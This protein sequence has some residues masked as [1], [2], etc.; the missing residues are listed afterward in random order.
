MGQWWRGG[1][2]INLTDRIQVYFVDFSSHTYFLLLTAV[3]IPVLSAAG[4][5]NDRERQLRWL[6]KPFPGQKRT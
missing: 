5:V 2:I 4:C 6:L 1:Q 3:R